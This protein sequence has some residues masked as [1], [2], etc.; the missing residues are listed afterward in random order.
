M[1]I[2][3]RGFLQ[4]GSMTA[5][6]VVVTGGLSQAAFGQVSSDKKSVLPIGGDRADR[7]SE[8]TRST[9]DEHIFS[10]FRFRVKKAGWVDLQLVEV[11]NLRPASSVGSE[12]D[13]KECYSL[14]FQSL[15]DITLRQGTYSLSHE[16]LGKFELFVV[17]LR[18][19]SMRYVAIINRLF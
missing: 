15:S 10:T 7:L 18:A 1:V 19:E 6:A 9:F 2:S 17:P 4:A 3:R 16:R 12:G 11:Q 8:L 14:V 5:V 13:G